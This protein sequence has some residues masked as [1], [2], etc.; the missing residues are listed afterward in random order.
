MTGARSFSLLQKCPG[1]ALEPSKLPIQQ[2][3]TVEQQG[4]TVNCSSPS[5]AKG[6]NEWSYISAPPHTFMVWTGTTLPLLPCTQTSYEAC[7][8]SYPTGTGSLSL[9]VKWPRHDTNCSP[10]SSAGH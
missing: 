9:Q 8:A 1:P 3:Y 5:S 6:K 10:A 4:H 2:V 7:P